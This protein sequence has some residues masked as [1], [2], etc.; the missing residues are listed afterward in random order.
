MIVNGQKSH[1]K[2]F[3]FIAQKIINFEGNSS[4]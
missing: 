3:M 1:L 4:T 2:K